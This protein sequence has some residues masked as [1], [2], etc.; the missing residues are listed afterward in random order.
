[1]GMDD[2]LFDFIF[3]TA[4][5]RKDTK[6][7]DE[8]LKTK[9]RPMS[10]SFEDAVADLITDMIVSNIDYIARVIIENNPH[11]LAKNNVDVLPML[12]KGKKASAILE[13]AKKQ[14]RFIKWDTAKILEAVVMVLSEKSITFDRDELLWLAKNVHAVGQY[15]YS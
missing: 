3:N 9:I 11:E 6:P 5:A 1:M 2:T 12:L 15:L 13:G 4:K 7:L 8:R 14:R 10:S